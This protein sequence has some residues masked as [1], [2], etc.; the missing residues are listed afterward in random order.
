MALKYNADIQNGK[1]D[2]ETAKQTQKEAFTKYF[3]EISA[4]ASTYKAD[5][6]LVT[7][8]IPDLTQ[9]GLPIPA[10]EVGMFEEGN[11]FSVSA[12]QPVFAGGQII[13]SNKLAK[14]AVEASVLQLD[15]TTDNVELET[16]I[17]FWKIVSLKEAEKTILLIRFYKVFTRM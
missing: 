17:Y 16:E 7:A 2:I 11:I 12:I 6:Y 13:N 14:T 5:D 4:G 1:I 3:P 15:V 10:M 9:L 8:N